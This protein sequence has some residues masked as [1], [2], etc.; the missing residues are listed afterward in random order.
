MQ[1]ND[2]NGLSGFHGFSGQATAF[3]TEGG[4]TERLDNR[5]QRTRFRPPSD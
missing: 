5:R 4:F 1:R 3:G 2:Y